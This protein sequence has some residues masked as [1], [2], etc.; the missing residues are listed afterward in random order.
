MFLT[1]LGWSHIIDYTCISEDCTIS[2]CSIIRNNN[3]LPHKVIDGISL[4]PEKIVM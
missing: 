3:V 2:K 1:K 4:T